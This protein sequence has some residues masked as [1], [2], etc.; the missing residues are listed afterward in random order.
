MN[1]KTCPGTSEK[2]RSSRAKSACTCDMKV[3]SRRLKTPRLRS[4]PPGKPSSL[5]PRNRVSLPRLRR[6]SAMQS[7][8][9]KARKP[10]HGEPHAVNGPGENG[11]GLPPVNRPS[12]RYALPGESGLRHPNQKGTQGGGPS[13]EGGNRGT[14]R[15]PDER[16]SPKPLQ[17][18]AVE[19]GK[20][21]AF[22]ESTPSRLTARQAEIR[23]GERMREQ[24]NARGNARD[25]G[26]NFAPR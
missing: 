25:R 15:L 3:A 23:S 12:V 21:A 18:R 22:S 9:C 14:T 26:A 16:R 7:V 8:A 11:R 17:V 20:P 4:T 24:A 5:A 10:E 6:E 1:G 13:V 2:D 19:R